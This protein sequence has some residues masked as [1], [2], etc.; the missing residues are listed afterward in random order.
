MRC[1]NC[2]VAFSEINAWKGLVLDPPPGRRWSWHC[3]AAECPECSEIIVKIQRSGDLIA[4]VAGGKEFFTE[5]LAY[6]WFARAPIVSLD[7][8]EDF[9]VDYKEACAVLPVSAKS[10]A[11]M[12]RRV[13]QSI[14]T[15]QGYKGSSLAAQIDKLLEEKDP[16]SVLPVSVKKTVD[17]IRNFGNFSTHPINDVMTLQIIDVEPGEAEWC[18]EIVERLFEHYYARPAEDARRLANLNEKLVQAGKPAAKG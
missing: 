2:S 13:L 15:D 6:P 14:L 3:R 8:P 5:R 16:D 18:L 11:A 1:P 12:S 4:R 7:V 10:S 17:A 9:V